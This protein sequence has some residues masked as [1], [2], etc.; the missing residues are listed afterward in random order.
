MSKIY[1]VSLQYLANIIKTFTYGVTKDKDELLNVWMLTTDILHAITSPLK[2]W[3]DK[4]ILKAVLKYSKMIID[5]FLKHGMPLLEAVFKKKNVECM[6]VIKKLQLSTKYMHVICTSTKLDT[7]ISLANFVPLLKK[8]LEATVYRVEAML[9]ANNLS[10]AFWL[11]NLKNKDLEGEEIL[12]QETEE[13]QEE[14]EEEAEDEANDENDDGDE[15]VELNDETD[16][17]SV[18]YDDEDN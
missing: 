7:D 8:S 17:R 12:S 2:Q 13:E 16:P 18:K 10:D 6:S 5:Q 14:E 3:R 1:L 11:G 4:P 9:A 15:E